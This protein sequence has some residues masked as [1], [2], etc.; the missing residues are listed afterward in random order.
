MGPGT[1]FFGT[2]FS[3]LTHPENGAWHQFRKWGLAPIFL[4]PIFLAPIFSV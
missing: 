2:N 4:A 3:S 1:N